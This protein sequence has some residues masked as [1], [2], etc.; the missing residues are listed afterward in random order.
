MCVLELVFCDVKL[1]KT[2]QIIKTK[3]TSELCILKLYAFILSFISLVSVCVCV[4]FLWINLQ[5]FCRNIPVDFL[6]ISKLDE[7][8]G[9][10]STKK[11]W[12]RNEKI[13]KTYFAWHLHQM[14]IFSL[15]LS[16][17]FLL[18]Q[19]IEHLLN[20]AILWRS[21]YVACSFNCLD[22]CGRKALSEFYMYICVYADYIHK[23]CVLSFTFAHQK[24]RWKKKH[25]IKSFVLFV[26]LCF[27]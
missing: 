22:A 25:E 3:A 19:L 17:F 15:F 20:A 2:T 21:S 4:L 26:M 6:K 27:A 18:S 12:K 13:H 16:L 11:N 1:S 23:N 10:K 24:K 8:R 9:K 7:L 5:I 14:G